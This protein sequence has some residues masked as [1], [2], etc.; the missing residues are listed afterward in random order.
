MLGCLALS[1][2]ACSK[3]GGGANRFE[4]GG[5]YFSGNAKAVKGDRAS[6][7]ATA[8]PVSA[9]LDGAIEAAR[10]EGVKYC[11]KYLGTSNIAWQVGPDTPKEQLVV[12]K[13]GL[14][15]RGTCVE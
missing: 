13:N 3:L 4:Y 14:T 11:I 6:F 15:F 8:K 1:L 9:S 5:V 2:T 12:E 10:Y 7:V